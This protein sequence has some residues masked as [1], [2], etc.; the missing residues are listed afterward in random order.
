MIPSG[1]SDLFDETSASITNTW[2][3]VIS[4]IVLGSVTVEEGLNS[5]KNF[6]DSVDGDT[7]LLEL[8]GK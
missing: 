3:E 8:N 4:Q 6:W 1:V 5:Y 7:M 2:K